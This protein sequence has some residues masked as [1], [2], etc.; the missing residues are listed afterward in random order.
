MTTVKNARTK[1]QS[2][3]EAKALLDSVEAMWVCPL[4]GVTFKV[5]ELK[6]IEAHKAK[7]FA[8]LEA[9]AEKKRKT[10]L[11]QQVQKTY[12]DSWKTVTDL[13]DVQKM[14]ARYLAAMSAPDYSPTTAQCKAVEKRIS[15]APFNPTSLFPPG[16]VYITVAGLTKEDLLQ[17]AKVQQNLRNN[18]RAG[19]N[20]PPVIYAVSP[21]TPDSFR[22]LVKTMA[23]MKLTIPKEMK[24]QLVADN[25]DYEALTKQKMAIA[26]EVHDLKARY[27]D[28]EAKLAAMRQLF[29]QDN[30]ELMVKQHMQ[31]VK[32]KRK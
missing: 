1:V 29:I 8:D 23:S 24:S 14:L 26:K 19:K 16:G 18:Y 31:S 4:T 11:L 21:A 28:I 13:D 3:A 9:E 30:F 7:V 17:L 10:K 20:L 12:A 15:V 5:T 6:K 27:N 32:K 25:P 22:L 2:A